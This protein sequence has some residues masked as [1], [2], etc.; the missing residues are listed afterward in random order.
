[1]LLIFLLYKFCLIKGKSL[2]YFDSPTPAFKFKMLLDR[3]H[4][5]SFVLFTDLPRRI[6][7]SVF[8]F[9]EI[10]EIDCLILLN[11]G[12]SRQ[13]PKLQNLN[14]LIFHDMPKNYNDY[15]DK[16]SQV[17]EGGTVLNLIPEAQATKQ[18][19]LC[20]KIQRKMDNY[21]SWFEIKIKWN[22]FT[23][24][25]GNMN[26]KL[27]SFSERIVK[28]VKTEMK[29][30]HLEST[31]KLKAYLKSGMTKSCIPKM[32]ATTEE[33][34]EAYQKEHI[35]SSLIWRAVSLLPSDMLPNSIL[36]TTV[37]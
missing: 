1:M 5:S 14:S 10:G 17:G 35:E 20:S 26:Q 18:L 22:E 33:T 24:I 36:R 11:T 34:T 6:V 13:P 7:N 29:T 27:T 2:V 23:A 31:L 19:V 25:Q 3:F 30:E 37:V 15:K 8:H 12:Y 9:Y 28:K 21:S 32:K 4:I 16:V